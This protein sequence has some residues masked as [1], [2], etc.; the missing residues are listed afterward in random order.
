MLITT[1][2]FWLNFF[3]PQMFVVLVDLPVLALAACEVLCML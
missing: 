3:L 1:V 2:L